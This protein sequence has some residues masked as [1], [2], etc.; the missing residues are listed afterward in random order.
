MSMIPE[1]LDALVALWRDGAPAGLR[2]DQVFDGPPAGEY[3][4]T[5]GVA[6][7]ASV[8]DNAVEFTARPA[9]LG[10]QRS[11]ERCTV[12]CLVW[13]GSGDTAM[14]PHRARVDQ[15]L[16][17]LDQALVDDRTLGGAVSRIQLVSGALV[18]QQTGTGALVTVEAS[19][20]VSLL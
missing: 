9:D 4:G 7:G 5:E 16:E 13:S 19:L 6:V 1:V 12:P 20:Q 14:K 8:Q 17:A 3:V 18:Q 10:W 15:I 2:A 11:A